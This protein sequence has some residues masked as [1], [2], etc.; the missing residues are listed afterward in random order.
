MKWA[1]KTDPEIIVHFKAKGYRH[2]GIP[3]WRWLSSL[4]WFWPNPWRAEE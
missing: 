1:M 3:F 4:D 2:A